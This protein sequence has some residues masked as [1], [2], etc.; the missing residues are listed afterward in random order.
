V[1]PVSTPAVRGDRTRAHRDRALF[2]RLRDP[3]DPVDRAYVVERFIPLARSV[4]R[5]HAYSSETFDDV[6]QV[7]CVGL[8][9]AVDRFD[10]DRRIA[11]TSYA[12]PTISGEIKRY[13]RDRTWMVRPPRAMQELAVRVEKTMDALHSRHGHAPTVDELAEALEVSDEDVLEV[14]QAREARNATSLDAPAADD[15]SK[16]GSSIGEL[17][18]G[19]DEGY[20]AVEARSTIDGLLRYLP[21]RDRDIV[22]MRFE[23][24]LSQAEI[25]TIK[26]LSQMQISRILRSSLDRVRALAQ[27]ERGR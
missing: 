25:G 5:A 13:Y 2:I 3:D 16:S 9:K 23:Y 21:E 24:G 12:V 14:L 20:G 22:R 17:L 1:T 19:R 26:G 15:R 7:A 11:F 8:V 27:A 18:G 4:T 10:P 6:F